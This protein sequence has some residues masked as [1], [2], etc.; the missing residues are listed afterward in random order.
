MAAP[1]ELWQFRFSHFNEKAR[2][3]LDW[4][5]VA[6]RRRSFLPGPHMLPV[7][8][9]TGQKQVPVLV[10]DG[11]AIPDSTAIIAALE[12]A[13]PERPLYPADPALRE[14][15]LAL[16]EFFDTQLGPHIRRAFFYDLLPHSDW[17]ASAMSVGFGPAARFA[18]RAFFPVT[19]FLMRTDMRIDASGA[20]LGRAKTLAALDR[21]EAELG[22]SG[23]LVGDA[24]SVADLTA[25]A[26]LAPIVTPPEFPYVPPGPLPE[27]AATFRASV[28]ERRAFRWAEEMFRRHRGRSAEIAA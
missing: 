12:A 6:H 13:Y 26:L 11:K 9:G 27:P 16:E 24:F 5:G 1:P 28:A 23:Y 2:W 25:A 14:R 3:A 17:A 21:V 4:K 18:Y 15:A 22:P 8:W 7:L 19:R 10:L 20:E